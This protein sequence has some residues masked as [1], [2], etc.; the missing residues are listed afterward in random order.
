MRIKVFGNSAETFEIPGED[1]SL[2]FLSRSRIM[3][4]QGEP[5]PLERKK[6]CR[7]T[8]NLS[9]EELVA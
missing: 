2:Y 3:S 7:I 5:C 1:F 9:L 4:S 8:K 6:L